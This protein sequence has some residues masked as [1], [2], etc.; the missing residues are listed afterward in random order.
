[1]KTIKDRLNDF[2]I[3]NLD[4]FER[5]QYDHFI[6][7]ISKAEALQVLINNVEDDTTQLSEQLAYIAQF[8]QRMHTIEELES[9]VFLN[10]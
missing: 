9:N 8:Q 3:N 4:L 10:Q 6:K 2:E 7:S 5:M 1:M